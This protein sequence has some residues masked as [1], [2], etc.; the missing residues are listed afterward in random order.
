MENRRK[1][2]DREA[3]KQ[4]ARLMSAAWS[5]YLESDYAKCLDLLAFGTPALT[6][7]ERFEVALLRT[8]ALLRCGRSASAI[9][10]VEE[11]LALAG[12]ASTHILAL[13]FLGTALRRAKRMRDADAAF[14]KGLAFSDQASA[15]ARSEF[16]YL[17]AV[18][19]W[20][21]GDMDR[22]RNCAM[23][24]LPDAQDVALAALHQV[25][26]WIE[27]RC[28]RYATAAQSFLQALEVLDGSP[29]DDLRLRARLIHALCVIAS[30][31]IDL[32]LW[33]RIKPAVDAMRWTDG[34]ARAHFHTLVCRSFL[35][36]LE[37]KLDEAWSV[38][39]EALCATQTPA[40]IAIASTNAGAIDQL[41]GDAYAARRNFSRAWDVISGVR[42]SEADEEERIAL[43]NFAIEAPEDLKPYARKAMTIY[44]SV[45]PRFDLGLALHRD[46]RVAAF[47]ATAS[48]RIAEICGN[49][50]EAIGHYERSLRLWNALD[51][52]M[53]AALVASR[54]LRLTHDDQ[55]RADINVAAQR[56]KHAW[57]L[58]DHTMLRA[59]AASAALS[60]LTMTERTVLSHLLT[61]KPARQIADALSR[62]PHT[63]TNH[64][65]RIFEAFGVTSRS[66]LIARCTQLGLTPDSVLPA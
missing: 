61:G 35:A 47:E 21:D 32:Q 1:I 64:T 9:D 24:A 19:A 23:Q 41:V 18:A 38:S 62:S 7:D 34:V 26:G 5:A 33:G 53:R 40:F 43:A 52:R 59:G 14:T 13:G 27:I 3:G 39:R 45:A 6:K 17:R 49:T 46:R 54:L 28:E 2:A 42:W 16:A 36:L 15:E 31:T 57:F 4:T 22:A 11:A 51:Y 56:A 63:I 55:Y 37:G 8:R 29:V 58:A 25:I 50:A 48:G 12:D 60:H 65:R 66:A 30:E 44:R 10:S 20:E